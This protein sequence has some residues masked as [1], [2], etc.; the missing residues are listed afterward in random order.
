MANNEDQENLSSSNDEDE[1]TSSSSTTSSEDEEDEQVDEESDSNLATL[2]PKEAFF[3]LE[4]K[5]KA[6][7]KRLLELRD[8]LKAKPQADIDTKKRLLVEV[9]NLREKWIAVQTRLTNLKARLS[10]SPTPEREITLKVPVKTIRK[11]TPTKT[12]TEPG[13]R[14]IPP[15]RERSRS[16]SSSSRSRSS[17]KDST[18]SNEKP[19]HDL[20]ALDE[21]GDS[22]A[23]DLLLSRQTT[24]YR[25]LTEDLSFSPSPSPSPSSSPPPSSILA[26]TSNQIGLSNL[27]LHEPKTFEDK[28]DEEVEDVIN[29]KISFYNENIPY[30]VIKDKRDV[31]IINRELKN[32]L[33]QLEASKNNPLYDQQT[34]PV[35]YERLKKQIEYINLRI[36]IEKLKRMKTKTQREKEQNKKQFHVLVQEFRKLQ[37]SMRLANRDYHNNT[38]LTDQID[39]LPAAIPLPPSPKRTQPREFQLPPLDLHRVTGKKIVFE[40]SDSDDDDQ[41]APTATA[42]PQVPV[43]LSASE[44]HAVP[45][46]NKLPPL[47]IPSSSSSSA[48]LDAIKTRLTNLINAPNPSAS[49]TAESS[50]TKD[51][52]DKDI[53]KNVNNNN[54][55]DDDDD[56]DN[57]PT[58]NPERSQAVSA[59]FNRRRRKAK[60][61]RHK[62]KTSNA[63]ATQQISNENEATT[64][65]HEEAWRRHVAMQL[66]FSFLKK[67]NPILRALTA[68]AHKKLGVSEDQVSEFQF[69]DEMMDYETALI[70]QQQQEYL[71]AKAA[72]P[73]NVL[74]SAAAGSSSSRPN[75]VDILANLNGGVPPSSSEPQT[76]M[77]LLQKFFLDAN[78]N[79]NAEHR[80]NRGLN[81]LSTTPPTPPTP[82]DISIGKKIVESLTHQ[83]INA[84]LKLSGSEHDDDDDDDEGDNQSFN[85]DSDDDMNNFSFDEDSSDIPNGNRNGNNKNYERWE[86]PT[87]AQS[88]GAQSSSIN[89]KKS[90]MESL[91]LPSFNRCTHLGKP[92]KRSVG[93]ERVF[94]SFSKHNA[95]STSTLSLILYGLSTP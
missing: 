66:Q 8:E 27:S 6:I 2:T 91:I 16:Y 25:D 26:S 70:L 12:D 63:Q 30:P 43:S 54:D 93:V 64:V 4:S 62:K 19:Y 88:R 21:T 45:D 55:G 33:R 15:P 11:A 18:Q 58:I 32:Q 72:N 5:R 34:G 51:V 20:D 17:S 46:S 28:F 9:K 13:T 24:S 47:P 41:P 83:D 23:R 86:R 50:S 35:K 53:Q 67:S 85:G 36:R 38:F 77:G 80:S 59:K 84:L 61:N 60:R 90:T 31:E 3:A 52:P 79:S 75:L 94:P 74:H 92:S 76:P 82:R 65:D 10:R 29:P 57:Q 68:E 49:Q 37:R 22:K 71:A 44:P 81:D 39:I 40:S 89:N 48:T 73:F 69:D 1:T 95:T 87:P 78:H 56:K 14:I 42:E 7:G